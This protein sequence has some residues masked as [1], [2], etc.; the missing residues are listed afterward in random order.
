MKK[1]INQS[2][3]TNR[4][5]PFFLDIPLFCQTLF[6][7][8]PSS[9][10]LFC[11]LKIDKFIE[12]MHC[13]VCVFVSVYVYKNLLVFNNHFGVFLFLPFFQLNYHIGFFFIPLQ[14]KIMPNNDAIIPTKTTTIRIL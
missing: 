3:T 8:T 14:K 11:R 5:P 6:L 12:S 9:T 7:S 4:T 13:V 1:K 2:I 10:V